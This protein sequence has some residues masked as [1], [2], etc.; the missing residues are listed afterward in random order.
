MVLA[1]YHMPE[2]NGMELVKALREKH[3]KENLAIIGISAL[4]EK[5]LSASFIKYGA[6]DCSDQTIFTGRTSVPDKP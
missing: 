4:D 2:M 6:N 5:L 1:N 3:D